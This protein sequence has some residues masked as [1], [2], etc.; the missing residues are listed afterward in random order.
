M[1]YMNQEKKKA[2]AAMIKAEFPNWSVRLSVHHHSSIR[3]AIV[4]ADIDLLAIAKKNMEEKAKVNPDRYYRE[5]EDGNEVYGNMEDYFGKDTEAT[6]R[7]K[8]FM[9]CVN[10]VGHQYQNHDNSDAMTD[11]FDVGYYTY[12]YIGGRTEASSFKYEPAKAKRAK[13]VKPA[14][15]EENFAQAV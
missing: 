2:I 9:D 1:A 5:F 3:V 10:L 7:M 6:A 12:V 15:N 13:K 8:K 4:R 11:Y 14:V